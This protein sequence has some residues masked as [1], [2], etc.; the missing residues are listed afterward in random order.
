MIRTYGSAPFKVAVIHGGP[1][2]PGYMA[3]VARELKDSFGVIEPIQTAKSLKGQIEELHDQIMSVTHDP[4]CLV[5]SS[6]GATLALFYA[7]NYSRTVNKVI[8]VGSCVYDVASSDR[9]KACI[10]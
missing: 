1:G 2:S 10:C 3:P 5:G 6:W 7:A 4:I 8:L 9:V